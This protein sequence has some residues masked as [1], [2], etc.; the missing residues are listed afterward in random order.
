MIYQQLPQGIEYFILLFFL[1]AEIHY[2]FKYFFSWL[3]KSEPEIIADLPARLQNDRPLPILVIIKDADR[4]PVR[5]D[6]LTVMIDERE[7]DVI[8]LHQ[9]V[10]EAFRDLQIEY[11]LPDVQSGLVEISI[12]I[13]Y[14]CNGKS[15]HCYNDNHRGTAHRAFPVTITNSTLPRYEGCYLGETHCHTN[16]TSDQVEFGGAVRSTAMLAK[17]MG[18]DFYCATDH[19]YDLDDLPENYLENDPALKKWQN[20][21]QEIQEFNR[22]SDDFM[23]I[24]G[25]EVTVLNHKGRNVHCLVYNSETFFPGSGD[26][27]EKWLRWRSELALD[28]VLAQIEEQVKIFAA[29]PFDKPPFLQRIFI[30]RGTWGQTDC[31]RKGIHGLQFINGGTKKQTQRAKQNWINLLL[32]G[33]KTIGLAGN[34]AHGNFARFRQVGFPFFTMREHYHHLFGH[35]RT[36]VYCQG[37]KLQPENLLDAMAA[38]K[39]YMSNGPALRFTGVDENNIIHHSGDTVRNLKKIKV[40]SRSSEEYGK[41]TTII[42]YYGNTD[43]KSEVCWF[44]KQIPEGVLDFEEEL[45]IQSVDY[46]GYFR[47]EVFTEK[48]FTALSN[49]I[50]TADL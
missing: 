17:A 18:L 28:E 50:W 16:Y 25:E 6:R 8:E 10:T 24:P 20:F 21:K 26:S 14:Y 33:H 44:T 12:R 40:E 3:H 27:G 37:Q 35:W 42:V 5:I 4:Y 49:P 7:P 46:P 19:S 36:G 23:I 41:L 29:H 32:S 11:P 48:G 22:T 31:T 15:R 34:D 45:S 38:G 9:E 30:G 2:R 43:M 39:C 1:Y 13:D 47:M